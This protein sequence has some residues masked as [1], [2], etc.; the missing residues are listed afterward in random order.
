MPQ[1]LL[2]RFLS[3]LL[4]C[5]PQTL[6]LPPRHCLSF[7]SPSGGSQHSPSLKLLFPPLKETSLFSLIPWSGVAPA[8]SIPKVDLQ[9][10]LPTSLYPR[11]PPGTGLSPV[12]AQMAIP[13]RTNSNT[14]IL[15][16]NLESVW[17]PV[18]CCLVASVLSFCDPVDCSPP[19]SSVLEIF[20][21]RILEWVVIS[22]SRGSSQPRDRTCISCIGRRVLYR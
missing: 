14:R 20:Q 4:L 16:W 17:F 7:K 15:I 18:V 19:G 8:P 11:S 13:S 9:E 10:V 12:C 5:S 2:L 6:P 21:A 3:P 22:S 1:I